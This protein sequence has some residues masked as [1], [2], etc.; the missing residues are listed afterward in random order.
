MGW[1]RWSWRER[2]GVIGV[3]CVAVVV[4]LAAAVW[5]LWMRFGRGAGDGDGDVGGLM[6]GMRRGRLNG[7][8]TGETGVLGRGLR[9]GDVGYGS[10]S[11]SCAS[12]R[13]GGRGDTRVQEKIPISVFED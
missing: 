3:A 13:H 11:G 6:D 9:V 2:W 4:L 7:V 1:G 12:S 8:R 5:A 10:R